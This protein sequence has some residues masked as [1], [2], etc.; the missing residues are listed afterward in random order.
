MPL[1]KHLF[2]L[3]WALERLITPGA[4]SSQNAYARIV[5]SYVTP[6]TRWLE[7][8][9][10]HQLWPEWIPGQEETA[11][12]A[13]LLVGLDPDAGSLQQ[14]PVIHH[15]VVG[16]TLPFRDGSFDLVTANMVFEHLEDPAAVLRD[17]GRVLAPGG[18][19][20]F[21][22]ANALYWQTVLGRSL[23]QWIKNTLVEFSE[24]RDAA[25]VYPTHYRINTERAIPRVLENAGFSADR[26]EMLNT[27]A[28]GRILLL[29]PLVVLEL[30]WIRLT[31][32]PRLSA[33]RSNIIAVIR[34]VEERAQQI[35]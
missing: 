3:Y 20:I 29:G 14:N 17:I 23:P 11:K 6:T 5:K 19:C 30:L 10:G 28:A 24:G 34:P 27:S 22:T 31:R 7:V 8:G 12:T 4:E 13:R 32:R 25:D 33:H 21:H 35:A 26:L 2:K 9:C 15:R 18:V 16:L 1:V